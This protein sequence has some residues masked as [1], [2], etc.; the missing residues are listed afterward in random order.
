[1]HLNLN[2]WHGV[3]R[4]VAVG[5]RVHRFPTTA[6]QLL[7]VYSRN[8]TVRPSLEIYEV[9]LNDGVVKPTRRCKLLVVLPRSYTGSFALRFS[10]Y[11]G[12]LTRLQSRCSTSY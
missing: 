9:T 7:Y 5:A 6:F 4:M 3:C 11:S 10:Y 1:M 12:R 2:S 8:Y